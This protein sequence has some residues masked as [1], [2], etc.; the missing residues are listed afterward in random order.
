[1]TGRRQRAAD[2]RRRPQATGGPRAGAVSGGRAANRDAPAND[3]DQTTAIERA[4]RDLDARSSGASARAAGRKQERP[5][6]RP[7]RAV[8]RRRRRV[9]ALTVA[10]VLAVAAWLIFSAFRSGPTDFAGT[11]YTS[12][13]L[14]GSPQL[15]I[16]KQGSQYTVQGLD[17]FGHPDK[18]MS[19]A[20][21]QLVAAGTTASGNRWQLVL[22][23]LDD[24]NQ[25]LATLTTTGQ[26]AQIDR[27]TRQ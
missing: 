2:S 13:N 1:M 4:L 8:V 11:W 19:L 10:I 27:Y 5:S 16:R 7:R 6:Q 23:L 25:I 9:A 14:L 15:V 20:G 17:V 12:S 21:G 18:T 22:Q 24:Q 26:A 3:S